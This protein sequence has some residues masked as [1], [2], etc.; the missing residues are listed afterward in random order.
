MPKTR[1]FPRE[2]WSVQGYSPNVLAGPVFDV[3]DIDKI[4]V[5]NKEGKPVFAMVRLGDTGF[6]QCDMSEPDWDTFCRLRG[7]S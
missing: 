5:R 1:P 3:D 7:I 6:T 4:I 2:T